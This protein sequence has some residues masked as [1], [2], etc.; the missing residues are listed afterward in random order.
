M[1]SIQ[2]QADNLPSYQLIRAKSTSLIADLS[3]EDCSLQASDFVSPAKWHLAHTTWFFETFILL[4]NVLG[5]QVF[6]PDF[7]VLFNSYYNGVGEQFSRPKRHLL[8]RPSLQK[9]LEYRQFVDVAIK[10]MLVNSSKKI[11]TLI[12]LGLHHEQQHQ[13]LLLMDLKYCFF[14]NPL[15]PRYVPGISMPEKRPQA[16][17]QERHDSP[18]KF[19]SF[20]ST[21]TDVGT[22]FDEQDFCF[23]NETPQ[24]QAYVQPYQLADRLV[25]NGEYLQFIESD[26][27]QDASLWLS[28]GWAWLRGKNTEKLAPLYW[29]K[30][31]DQWF[32][33]GLH[34]LQLLDLSKP[35]IHVNFY[36]AYA[37]A[38]WAGG[39][40]PT[41]FE[42]EHAIKH[43]VQNFT[44]IQ[45][46]AWQWTQSAY[47]P[48]PG[49]IKP[50]GAVGEYNGKF[51]CNQ[52]VLRGGS[53]LTPKAHA[54]FTYRNFFYPQDQW[55]MTGIRLALD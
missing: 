54:R 1:N 31:Q 50:Q 28:D 17:S 36:E 39:R 5:Y 38:Q 2:V 20:E 23:D 27:Y 40:L 42:W 6:H 12:L 34:G 24:H 7:Q 18:I 8:S 16:L 19:I 32:E 21:L 11:E 48:Y 49:F 41:E 14:Q 33:F 43:Q 22:Q 46:Q 29:V 55:P 52:M 47:Q 51:M 13:E 37:Y 25:T 45:D 53:Q 30:K 15:Y 3:P 26:G 4:P 35:V 9:V 10:K 44:Q